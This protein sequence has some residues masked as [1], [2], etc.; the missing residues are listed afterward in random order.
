ML[1]R[2]RYNVFKVKTNGIFGGEIEITACQNTGQIEWELLETRPEFM[3]KL[4]MGGYPEYDQ[5]IK[6]PCWLGRIEDEDGIEEYIVLEPEQIAVMYQLL[7][8]AEKKEKM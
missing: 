1:N 7:L 2:D 5:S 3:D 8:D 4:Y 6:F